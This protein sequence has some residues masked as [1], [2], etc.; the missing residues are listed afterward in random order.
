MDDARYVQDQ[1]LVGN[2]VMQMQVQRWP[3]TG[4]LTQGT[5]WL[6]EGG[7]GMQRAR[8]LGG[9]VDTMHFRR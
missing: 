7:L 1:D 2:A 6:Y 8:R 9:G 3:E 4:K 5:Y